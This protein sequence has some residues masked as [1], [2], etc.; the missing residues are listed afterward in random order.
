MCS[1]LVLCAALLLHIPPNAAVTGTSQSPAGNTFPLAFTLDSGALH[2]ESAIVYD[3]A[4][5]RILFEK[6]AEMELPLASLTKL[7]TA[8]VV[9]ARENPETSVVI[10]SD[11]TAEVNDKGDMGL[12]AGQLWS[13]GELVRYGLFASSNNAMLAAAAAASI[14]GTSTVDAMNARA[15][16]LGLTESH[17]YN[18][19]G[20]D[21]NA[22]LSGGY[23][24]ARDVAVLA[25]DFYAHNPAFFEVTMRPDA[26]FG[27]GGE[28]VLAE[29]TAAPIEDIPGILGAKTG[30]TDLAL[31]NVV[32]VFDVELGH[33]LV[34]VVLHST[35]EGR[36]DDIRTL[37]EAARS[38]RN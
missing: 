5:G 23:G 33:P 32:A 13:V 4:T 1:A 16:E 22:E 17:Y 6:N 31:G 10:S 14:D 24:S 36:F 37:I 21:I 18:P 28:Q 38:A 30:Y 26:S 34:A 9:L 25:S 35:E 7:M 20:L 27:P 19:T 29:P 15:R 2:A 12:R 3:P 11:H 8:D